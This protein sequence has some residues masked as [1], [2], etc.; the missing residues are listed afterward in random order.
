MSDIIPYQQQVGVS[1]QGRG[2]LSPNALQPA[3]QAASIARIGDNV[4]QLALTVDQNERKRLERERQ[5]KLGTIRNESRQQSTLGLL[6]DFQAAKQGAAPGAD[7]FYES[8][9]DTVGKRRQAALD[10]AGQ[11]P[12]ARAIVEE[13]FDRLALPF[14]ADAQEFQSVERVR[15]RT[16]LLDGSL[17][18]LGNAI[19]TSPDQFDAYYQEGLASIDA[20]SSDLSPDGRRKML[21]GWKDSAS[22]AA[23]NGMLEADPYTALEDAQSK[24]FDRLW[25]PETKARA[26][27]SA[28][29]EIKRRETAAK[30][31]QAEAMRR[32]GR[33]VDGAIKVMQAGYRYDGIGDLR[34]AVRGTEFEAELAFHESVA[35]ARQEHAF[36]P[37]ADQI[38]VLRQI[39]G[40]PQNEASLS[41]IKALKPV[42]DEAVKAVKSDRVLEYAA[43]HGVISL[44]PVEFDNP[45]SWGNRLR[46]ADAA[47]TM[48]G[49]GQ[50]NLLTEPE[51]AELSAFV[52]E[53]PPA[54]KIEWMAGLR[55]SLDD[56]DYRQV[57]RAMG[58]A[59][60]EPGLDLAADMIARSEKNQPAAQR[61]LQAFAVDE[62]ALPLEKDAKKTAEEGAL[63]AFNDRLG[64]VLA[65]QSD[66]LAGDAGRLNMSAE[67]HEATRRLAVSYAASGRG[68]GWFS[69]NAGQTAYDDLF[70]DYQSVEREDA[71]LFAEGAVGDL[72]DIVDGL[73]LIRDQHVEEALAWQRPLFGPTGS[74]N[75]GEVGNIDRSR[76]RIENPDGT[77]STEETI[78]ID[79]EVG[80]KT[81][82]FNIPTIV[83]GKRQTEDDAVRLFEEGKNKAVGEFDTLDEALSVARQRTEAIG[84]VRA[85]PAEIA[86]ADMLFQEYVR[87]IQDGGVWVNGAGGAVLVDPV[88]GAAIARP[89]GTPYVI[90]FEQAL[91][92]FEA[93]GAVSLD[94]PDPTRSTMIPMG[95]AR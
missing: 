76:P 77:F 26:I 18:A 58:K 40:Q 1:T 14:L 74:A 80:G 9:K 81:R 35:G 75:E 88:Q 38:E 94:A 16:D 52:Q 6:E 7:G 13:D 91:R 43:D 2:R 65:A 51:Q 50:A 79:M 61:L 32:L 45:E 53:M 57:Q 63:S 56:H 28:Q 36:R 67:M 72:G 21:D 73:R 69:G 4:A 87:D 49:I 84:Q 92:A 47:A 66:M 85:N 59:K 24:R 30:V 95:T 19:V 71:I 82:F 23:F 8:F 29:A 31:D 68:G 42:T 20:A 86:R 39:E 83:D 37:V 27:N 78:T 55:A 5:A 44:E 41:V 46:R 11:D 89:D 22:L 17:N 3:D 60:V 34:A 33:Q 93:N 25:S 62:K 15:H 90:S 64:S 70:G 48:A 10:L 54:E 12:D